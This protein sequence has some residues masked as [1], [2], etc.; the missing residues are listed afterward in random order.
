MKCHLAVLSATQNCRYHSLSDSDA[1]QRRSPNGR[2]KRPAD[3][4]TYRVVTLNRK[5]SSIA[6]EDIAA[7]TRKWY[8]RFPFK[9]TFMQR[10]VRVV[11]LN[12][13]DASAHPSRRN[14]C[15]ASRRSDEERARSYRHGSLT[16][17]SAIAF[18]R[19]N[20]FY[21]KIPLNLRN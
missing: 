14:R 18:A 10:I 12:R 19:K 5:L 3:S 16:Q 1:P 21:R 13:S 9:E 15:V 20:S 11:I 7:E 6:E 2:P 17:P 8:N 4:T